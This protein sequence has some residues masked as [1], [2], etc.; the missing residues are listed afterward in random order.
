MKL[1]ILEELELEI[2]GLNLSSLD[3][4]SVGGVR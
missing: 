4:L 3:S 2:T 1:E